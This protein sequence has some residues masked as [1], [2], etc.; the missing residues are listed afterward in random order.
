MLLRWRCCYVACSVVVYRRGV[1]GWGGCNNVMWT[2]LDWDLLKPWP[3]CFVEDVVTLQVSLLFTSKQ[4]LQKA[5]VDVTMKKVWCSFRPWFSS[6]LWHFL[7]V[8]KT[9]KHAWNRNS[10]GFYVAH[11]FGHPWKMSIYHFSARTNVKF[12]RA[13]I[14]TFTDRTIWEKSIQHCKTQ[15]KINIFH[16]H[17][18]KMQL[19]SGEPPAFTLYIY[20]DTHEVLYLYSLN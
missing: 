11:M 9:T 17:T 5:F 4:L 15:C 3:C 20:T 6:E 18:N 19:A 1:G 10:N 8:N 7:V 2:A 16:I 12:I 13:D 14:A